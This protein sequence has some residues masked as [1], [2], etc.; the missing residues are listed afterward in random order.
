MNIESHLWGGGKSTAHFEM[1]QT[2]VQ[3]H[4]AAGQEQKSFTKEQQIQ[5]YPQI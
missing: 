2:N 5:I 3:K 4:H 1:T